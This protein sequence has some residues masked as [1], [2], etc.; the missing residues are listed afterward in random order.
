M[1]REVLEKGQKENK[2]GW[3]KLTLGDAGESCAKALE[4]DDRGEERR[5]LDVALLADDGDEGRQRWERVVVALDR[6]WVD[7]G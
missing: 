3:A 7:R 4:V 2:A 1:C 5:D 6:L